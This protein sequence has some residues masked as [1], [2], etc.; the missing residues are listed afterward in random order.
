MFGRCERLRF[1]YFLNRLS[2]DLGFSQWAGLRYLVLS[3]LPHELG[4]LSRVCGDF[5]RQ[6]IG[7]AR[8]R[9]RRLNDGP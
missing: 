6:A 7:T 2:F 5:C 9:P 3:A 1:V 4:N 8:D